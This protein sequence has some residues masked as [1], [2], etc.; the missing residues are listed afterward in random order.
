MHMWRH[1]R[2]VVS[3]GSVR[4]MT[5][6]RSSASMGLAPGG[7]EGEANGF[8]EAA[9]APVGVVEGGVWPPPPPPPRPASM[10]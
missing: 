3:R 4:Q 9:A 6:A 8:W 7:E 2:A 5:H 1:G 10:P